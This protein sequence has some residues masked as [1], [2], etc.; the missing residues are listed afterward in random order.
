MVFCPQPIMN[1]FG[2][3]RLENRSW[4]I[5]ILCIL[6]LSFPAFC[7]RMPD[8]ARYVP[9]ELQP[10][11]PEVRNMIQSARTDYEAGRY[12]I[13]FSEEKTALAIAEKKNL[14]G[15]KALAEE[16]VASGYFA[17]GNL[18]ESIK[19]YRA[20]LQ[21]AIDSSNLVLQADVLVALSTSPQLQGNMPGALELLNSALDRANQ[22]KNV[23]IKSRVLGE[24]G[25][26]QVLSGNLNEGR[27][28]ISQA[29]EID[30]A[31]GYVYEALHT[32]YLAYAIL[33][34][35]PPTADPSLGIAKLEEARDL[36]MQ[37]SSYIALILAESSL[38]QILIRK[39]EVSEGIRT[40]E[41]A[42]DGKVFKDGKVVD[43]PVAFQVTIS[44]PYMKATLL[45]GLAQGYG[46]AQETDKALQAWTELYSYSVAS[47]MNVAEG[48]AALRL[49]T[50]YR[51]KR[52]ETNAL[53]FYSIASE[54]L[55]KLQDYIHL[56][57]AL[58]GEASFLIQLGKAEE[59][60]PLEHEIAEIGRNIHNRQA[61]FFAEGALAEIYDPEGKLQ[62]AKAALQQAEDLISPGP[63]DSEI[64]NKFV[65]EDYARSAVILKKLNDPIGEVIALEKGFATAA[66]IKDQ[67]ASD[68]FATSLQKEINSLHLETRIA[69][70]Y[71][72]GKLQDALLCSEILLIYNGPPKPP[73]NEQYWNL[74]LSLP[75]Q[76]AA[77]PDGPSALAN[78]LNALGPDLGIGRFP[79]LDALSQHYLYSENKPELARRYAVQALSVL[80]SSWPVNGIKVR[81]VC[82]LAVAYS[83]TREIELAHDALGKCL[84]YSNEVNDSEVKVLAHGADV[85]V[86]LSLGETQDA[87]ES[88][89]YLRDLTPDDPALHQQLAASLVSAGDTEKALSEYELVLHIYE[90]KNL[91]SA[92]ANTYRLMG[93]ALESSASDQKL[94]IPDFD[95]A[96]HIYEG[97]GDKAG[98]ASTQLAVGED[99]VKVKDNRDAE[100]HLR[101]AIKLAQ[102]SGRKDVEALALSNLGNIYFAQNRFSEAAEFLQKDVEACERS[103]NSVSEVFAL[104]E[105]GLDYERQVNRDEALATY[106]KAKSLASNTGLDFVE[107]SVQ[108]RLGWFY[109]TIGRY[110]ES[111]ASFREA[112]RVA[113]KAG[114]VPNLA[115]A[116]LN[117]GM[118]LATIGDW[119]GAVEA[120]NRALT[121]S[122]QTKN[123][124]TEYLA[125]AELMG[126]YSDR[127]S[128]LKDFDK[129]LKYYSDAVSLKNYSN[130]SLMQLD[131]L[132]IY[133]Q[134]GE[135]AKA[136]SSAKQGI[137][138]C[139]RIKDENCLANGLISLAEAER[140]EQ[141][142]SGAEEALRKA[143][144]LVDRDASFYLLGRYLYGRAGLERAKGRLRESVSSYEQVVNMIE[145]VK[146]DSAQQSQAGVEESYDFIYG[147][148]IDTLYALAEQSTGDSHTKDSEE[149]LRYC[150][151]NKARQFDQEWGQAFVARLR[152]TLPSNLQDEETLLIQRRDRLRAELRYSISNSQSLPE[153]SP[154]DIQ[155]D[156]DSAERDL[157][158]FVA[159]LRSTQP[160]YASLAYPEP[161]SVDSLPLHKGELVVEFKVTDD[162]TFVWMIEGSN[163]A[164]PRLVSFYK[165]PQKLQWIAQ[166]V[167]SIRD[168]FNT[169]T[170]DRYQAK[171]S[172]E[173]FDALF[174]PKYAKELWSH[175]SITVIP[176]DVLFLIPFEILSPHATQG[177]FALIATPIR[178]YP[179]LAALRIARSSSRSTDWKDAFLGV[180]DPITSPDDLR[181]TLVT[182]MPQS[183]ASTPPSDNSS[184]G[185]FDR[186]AAIKSRGY[187]FDRL[188]GTAKEVQDIET[189]VEARGQPAKIFLGPDATK[190]HVTSTDLAQFR[191]L[192]F[193]THGVLPTEGGIREPS[194]ILSFDGTTPQSMLFSVSDILRLSVR[195]DTV[196][197]SACNTGSGPVSRAEGVMSLGRAFMTAGAQSVTVSLWQ[198]SDNSTQMFMEEYYKN[199]LDGKPKPEAL[200][201]A[202]SYLFSKGFK[203]PFF[204]GPFVLIGE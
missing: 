129:A 193:A 133:L 88:L 25:R 143:K 12:E 80:G 93:I 194:L 140:H 111:V 120:V 90:K 147:D 17:A 130:A 192:H 31:N 37:K 195:A 151:S 167:E 4:L 22:S 63:M 13:A 87:E 148:L 7:Q 188:P 175:T 116:S 164:S 114:D 11:D 132:E 121:L 23:F 179:S 178:Y 39:G 173:L 16:D 149:A 104:L 33:A 84:E 56:A 76:I 71:K 67:N 181:Y 54:T 1:A 51:S 9:P 15:D 150:E 119:T 199:L 197:L 41:A 57:Q 55:R 38:G 2:S 21:D 29:L 138:E 186:I 123:G 185:G 198:V 159:S 91:Q 59:A 141:N 160:R 184:I 65:I 64:D 78:D 169:G 47:G 113:E 161:M 157:N 60:V 79:I 126:I 196:V 154:V 203:N 202:R 30:K 35:T 131:L 44:E 66:F 14:V 174:P 62:D 204:W 158:N 135:F 156:L 182:A 183:N 124:A 50:L 170:P 40:L 26:N 153:R 98:E 115:S 70:S 43:M 101:S 86:H 191:F 100:N 49:A 68:T 200:G 152:T 46:I 165:A 5:L 102:E 201:L 8:T 96:S 28:S 27:H 168:A 85:F 176:D 107:S 18:E 72:S 34:A 83:H 139:R 48:E 95:R 36:A 112:T 118:V 142:L 144:P 53:K 155:K 20:S 166:R 180:G 75:F 136:E 94:A 171:Y 117:L 58:N 69:D 89:A 73:G 146:E 125:D 6:G 122:Q 74:V 128:N 32:V 19:S 61:Q 134:R 187:S 52:D 42:R 81:S 99:L 106:L 24:L 145:T 97:L 127:T 103:G 172:E 190:S 82:T 110:E 3:L 177:D 10:A 163:A 105:L 162:A 108:V 189:L 92:I 45:E 109:F 77:M 137:D